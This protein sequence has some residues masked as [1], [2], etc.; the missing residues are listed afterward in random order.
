M[1]NRKPHRDSDREPRDP[2]SVERS[3]M[4]LTTRGPLDNNFNITF[5]PE[6]S[7][8]QVKA[9]LEALAD[10]YRACGG[11]GFE[12]EFELEDVLVGELI[13]A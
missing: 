13:H 12:V 2:E 8:Q 10:Y 1:A 4:E 6:V 7:P 5:S 9:I 11:V 3:S